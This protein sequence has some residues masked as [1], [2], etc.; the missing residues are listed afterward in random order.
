MVENISSTGVTLGFF[1]GY[2]VLDLSK[3]VTQGNTTTRIQVPN[4]ASNPYGIDFILYG[5]GF[6][7]NSEPGGI[8]VAEGKPIIENGV[9]TGFVPWDVN[10]DGVIWY[11]I[12][13]SQYYSANSV[14]NAKYDYY[15]PH[16]SDDEVTAPPTAGTPSVDGVDYDFTPADGSVSSG[17][18]TYNGYHQHSWFPLYANYF[19]GRG[20]NDPLDHSGPLPF[21]DYHQT[22]GQNNAVTQTKLTLTGVKLKNV[23][24]TNTGG[25]TFGYA[26]V[27]G[28]N[29]TSGFT[30][31]GSAYNPYS[32]TSANIGSSGAWNSFL[33]STYGGGDPID[34]SWAVYPAK[35]DTGTNE[36]QAHPHAGEPVDLEYICFVRVYTAA[37]AMNGA[38]GEI[39][40]EVCG[41]YRATGTGSGG[42][43]APSF[44]VDTSYNLNDLMSWGA[45]ITTTPV[46]NNQ[47]IITISNLTEAQALQF[48]LG[49]SGGTYVFINGVYAATIP[50]DVT[51]GS[52][53][54]QIINQSGTA[55]PFVTVFKLNP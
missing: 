35:Y 44:T 41:A 49:V 26:D 3:E 9:T 16:P 37:A 55:E 22:L 47:Q 7:G 42:A 48:T 46:S 53:T 5:N 4:S 31:Y 2:V 29:T 14:I 19:V 34:I 32:I 15:N 24:P 8:Q 52:Q 50:I 39:S 54:V 23:D 28:K 25:Y 12:A 18:I 33:G 10:Q 45:S 38:F 36:G 13:G 43:A 1:G 40:T 6:I 30:A 11:D 17:T 21:A 20:S 27:H 51:N